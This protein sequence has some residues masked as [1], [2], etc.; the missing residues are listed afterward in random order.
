MNNFLFEKRLLVGKKINRFL[1]EK[2][3]TKSEL[4]E[5]TKISRPTL[6][7]IINGEINNKSTFDTHIEK[8]LKYIDITPIELLNDRALIISK[9]LSSFINEALTAKDIAESSDLKESDINKWIK[10]QEV[11][12][13]YELSKVAAV[14]GTSSRCLMKES[15][16]GHQSVLP[17]FIFSLNKNNKN[18]SGF[19]GHIGVQLPNEKT[20]KLYPVSEA[21]YSNCFNDMQNKKNIVFPTLN[22]RVVFVN[23]DNIDRIVLIDDD[24]DIVEEDAIIT[25]KGNPYPQEFYDNA[26]KVIWDEDLDLPYEV[27]EGIKNII[28]ENEWNEEDI[29]DLVK[30]TFIH[31]KN[32]RVIDL[33][34]FS[35]QD[36]GIKFESNYNIDDDSPIYI[37]DNNGAES[38]IQIKNIAIIDAPLNQIEEAINEIYDEYMNI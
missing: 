2:D 26:L 31:F 6:N 15:F 1:Q 17:N 5:K 9:N 35:Y 22:N 18:I 29:L 8:I 20:Y 21:A 36:I 14:L 11:P 27:E 23:Q 28:Q 16:F 33:S 25:N 30:N 12:N 3:I 19:W 13:N 34:P 24:C 4:C 37:S 7:K 10:G 32:G 38:F